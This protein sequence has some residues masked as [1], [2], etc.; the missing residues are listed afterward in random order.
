MAWRAYGKNKQK[1]LSTKNNST[2]KK[3][4]RAN[5]PSAPGGVYQEKLHRW[6]ATTMAMARPRRPSA[7]SV[8]VRTC[9]FRR[10]HFQRTVPN[11]HAMIATDPLIDFVRAQRERYLREL[12]DWIACPSVSA[13]PARHDQVRRSAEVAVA[14]MRAA[15]LTEAAVLETDGLPVAF[16][17]WLHAPGAP[18]ILIYGH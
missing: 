7:T 8:P 16:G 13:D 5:A 18:T 15:G 9:S 10:R 11:P 4:V 17:S 14:R 2:P 1:P 3:P 6:N 12:G